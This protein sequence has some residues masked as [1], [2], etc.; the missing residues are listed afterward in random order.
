MGAGYKQA[1]CLPS[2]VGCWMFAG[3]GCRLSGLSGL[4]GSLSARARI[5][6]EAKLLSPVAAALS[7]PTYYDYIYLCLRPSALNVTLP[8]W[9]E[10]AQGSKINQWVRHPTFSHQ[11]FIN[12]TNLLLKMELLFS[13][14]DEASGRL[15]TNVKSE[16]R[17]L[18]AKIYLFITLL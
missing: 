18:R 3:E 13:I 15:E 12:S 8:W 4:S 6:R 1:R 17:S 7:A 14:I 10:I 5:D 16:P 11:Q 9:G 2:R